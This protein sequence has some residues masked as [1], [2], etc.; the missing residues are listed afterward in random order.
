MSLPHE[1]H[2]DHCPS[3]YVAAVLAAASI[4]V[5]RPAALQTQ[6]AGRDDR[7]RVPW[8]C[9]A[10]HTC[11]QEAVVSVDW[12]VAREGVA[13]VTRVAPVAVAPARRSVEAPR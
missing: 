2:Q 6:R 7:A 8:P 5:R 4:A 11:E 9:V 1:R 13:R 3:V 12:A 10:L